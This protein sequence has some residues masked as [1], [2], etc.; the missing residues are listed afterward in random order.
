MPGEGPHPRDCDHGGA[1]L[2]PEDP[3]DTCILRGLDLLEHRY[4]WACHEALEQAWKALRH[5]DDPRTPVLVGLIAVAACWLRRH[6]GNVRAA[7]VLLARGER[8]L[9]GP[10]PDGIDIEA[11]A[12]LAA[13]RAFV[14]TGV[15]PR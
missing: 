9:A 1:G 2:S 11:P 7:E 12:L 8:L 5:G 6:Q 3:P 14:D 13:T 4:F 10:L 15:W